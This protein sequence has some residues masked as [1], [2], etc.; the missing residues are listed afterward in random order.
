MAGAHLELSVVVPAFNEAEGIDTA[1]GEIIKSI[2]DADIEDFEVIVV[3]DGSTDGTY[4]QLLVSREKYSQLKSIRLSRNFGKEGALLAGLAAACGSAI[5]TIDADLQ[6]PPA[7]IPEM[8]DHWRSG[9]K[10]VHAVKRDRSVDNWRSRMRALLFNKI[11][12]K[13]CGLDINNSSDFKLLDQRVV[14]ILVNDLSERERFYRGL[15]GWVGFNQVQVKFD[16]S[17]RCQGSSHWSIAGL[18]NLALTA[19]LSFTNAPLRIVSGLG[20]LTLLFAMGLTINTLISWYNNTAVSGFST[21]IIT[22]LIIGSFIMISLG[23]VG[24]YIAR[25]YL[26][27]KGRPAYIVADSNGFI[28]GSE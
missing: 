24:E 28:D 21:I 1:V 15:S 27:T 6:H 14:N 5:I 13:L 16:V 2:R 12:T 22:L 10:I 26:E 11:F 9:A 19:T 8:V 25:I 17:A 20:V 18:I 3:D 7:L 4:S 23:I